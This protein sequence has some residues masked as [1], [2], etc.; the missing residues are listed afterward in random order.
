MRK[1]PL[2]E[3]ID[4]KVTAVL[5]VFTD[6]TKDLVA[7][8]RPSWV[9]G[10]DARFRAL[11]GK[12]LNDLPVVAEHAGSGHLDLRVEVFEGFGKPTLVSFDLIFVDPDLEVPKDS[13][14]VKDLLD[15]ATQVLWDNPEMAPV[16]VRG[17]ILVACTEPHQVE[18]SCA[19]PV[20]PVGHESLMGGETV[21]MDLENLG[22]VDEI[23][24]A[25]D[26]YDRYGPPRFDPD[27]RP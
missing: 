21:V 14:L 19:D 25:A 24:R 11:L 4:R 26:L 17:R 27:W 1:V 15:R 23:A 18:E 5:R 20:P 9:P 10:R 16:A 7:N 2:R 12:A 3:R 13:V 8:V 6:Q 22:F